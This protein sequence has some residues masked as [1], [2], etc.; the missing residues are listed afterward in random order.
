MY[1]LHN[2]PLS[3]FI[4][5][6][7]SDESN[8]VG[9]RPRRAR[10]TRS[11]KVVN[12]P[13]N[14]IEAADQ[15]NGS[16][17]DP[18]ALANRYFA[19]AEEMNSR[20]AM[21]LAVPFYRQALTLLM[22]ERKQMQQQLPADQ[23]HGLLA[24]AEHWE[25]QPLPELDIEQSIAELTEDLN[26]ASAQQVLAALKEFENQK[27]FLPST[28][29][30]L[31]GNAYI[32]LGK[33]EEAV[34]AFES[35]CKAEPTRLD[36]QINHG[37][38]L[39]AAGETVAALSVLRNVYKNQLDLLATNEKTALLRNLAAAEAKEGDFKSALELR[40]EWLNENPN[41]QPVEKWLH[42]IHQG[43]AEQQADATKIQALELLKRLHE[44]HPAERTVTETLAETLENS[45]F[46][47]EA[48]LLY[49]T[50]LRPQLSQSKPF[51]S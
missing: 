26:E 49:R 51:S 34:Q 50:L 12:N 6:S 37:G 5:S 48:S 41:G 19:M 21:E 32:L 23:L 8:M 43:L 38:A 18:A 27:G 36:L 39:L 40:M 10:S 47:Q 4:Y 14:Q 44:L 16:S 24:A 11:S 29:Y 33:P 2:L 15:P 7:V 20:G 13:N 28:G 45:G 1:F 42:W 22:A 17:G 25:Q 30:A 9:S 3:F 46:Y 31:R 35:G